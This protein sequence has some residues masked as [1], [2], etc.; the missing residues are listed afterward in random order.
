MSPSDIAAWIGAAS[1]APQ[2]IGWLAKQLVKPRLEIIS[3]PTATV[4]YSNLGP[5]VLLTV[6]ISADKKD[7]LIEKMSLE[8]LHKKGESR[9]LTWAWLTETP[10]QL[11]APTGE[12]M[13]LRKNQPA[14]ALKVSTLALTEKAII[15]QDTEWTSRYGEI[16]ARRMEQLN[17]LKEQAGNQPSSL[18]E[19]LIR[20]KEFRDELQFLQDNMYWREGQYEFRVTIKELSLH[21]PY[22]KRYS[23][24]L[25][26]ASVD[27][28]RK[29]TQIIEQQLR[30]LAG[31]TQFTPVWNFAY[32]EMRPQEKT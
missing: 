2:I 3:A 20:S 9:V 5:T 31:G 27:A 28:L 4:G 18:P 16:S 32:P 21:A 7:A 25:S 19:S 23:V 13:D 6:S 17:Y 8:A 14:I 1:W 11:A 24:F 26:K 30:A 15:F 22:T 10:L 12:I 29:N